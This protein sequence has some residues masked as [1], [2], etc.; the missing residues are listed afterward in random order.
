[1]DIG[2]GDDND[3]ATLAVTVA[4]SNAA[5][6]GKA[7]ASS[8]S[9]TP[10]PRRGPGRECGLVLFCFMYCTAV[11]NCLLDPVIPNVLVT[12]RSSILPAEKH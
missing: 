2:T 11:I 5:R 10:P 8:T 6:P 3:M 9:R 1:M 7:L 12:P 4:V